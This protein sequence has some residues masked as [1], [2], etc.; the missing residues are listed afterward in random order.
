MWKRFHFEG[1]QFF[2][3]V[4]SPEDWQRL[5]AAYPD[6]TDDELLASKEATYGGHRSAEERERR[7][8]FGRRIEHDGEKTLRDFFVENGMLELIPVR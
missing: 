1:N 6:L 7:P 8:N 4:E 2:D 3:G 5:R